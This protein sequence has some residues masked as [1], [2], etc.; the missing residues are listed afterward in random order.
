MFQQ[1]RLRILCTTCGRGEDSC[2]GLYLQASNML[3]FTSR[4]HF[5]ECQK[6]TSSCSWS[7]FWTSIC[8]RS[9]SVMFIL[10]SWRFKRY[11]HWSISLKQLLPNRYSKMETTRF[12]WCNWRRFGSALNDKDTWNMRNFLIRDKSKQL[13][14]NLKKWKEQMLQHEKKP[15]SESEY[16]Y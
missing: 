16:I 4:E 12:M 6:L 11:F 7:C 10:L 9:A 8:I 1:K 14:N 3:S 15:F 13:Q 5:L 2:S